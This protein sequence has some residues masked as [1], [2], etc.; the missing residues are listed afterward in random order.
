MNC[1]QLS[2]SMC[3]LLDISL[4]QNKTSTFY[5]LCGDLTE[6]IS[7]SIYE[8]WC[9]INSQIIANIDINKEKQTAVTKHS[10]LCVFYTSKFKKKVFI[11]EKVSSVDGIG[12]HWVFWGGKSYSLISF[13][14][15][16]RAILL[17]LVPFDLTGYDL[18]FSY[19]F[20]HRCQYVAGWP[21][22]MQHVTLKFF[23]VYLTC[24]CLLIVFYPEV[25][26]SH[27]KRGW[28]A[29]GFLWCWSHVQPVPYRAQTRPTAPFMPLTLA[30][31]LKAVTI[32]TSQWSR[33]SWVF[34][35]LPIK[36]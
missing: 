16:K 14:T 13:W 25:F 1:S 15:L 28:K 11:G 33:G 27:Q 30:L 22:V 23:S 26:K 35:A 3:K 6:S 24:E 20:I 19:F 31:G 2:G 7:N 8:I 12:L 18:L 29:P 9:F 10:R 17:N 34:C 5:F 21:S 32:L 4:K 36:S